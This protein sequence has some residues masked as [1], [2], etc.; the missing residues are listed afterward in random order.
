MGTVAHVLR[1][2]VRLRWLHL[3][4]KC[5]NTPAL[6]APL[7]T[8]VSYPFI[9][10]FMGGGGLVCVHRSVETHLHILIYAADIIVAHTYISG[11]AAEA[12]VYQPTCTGHLQHSPALCWPVVERPPGCQHS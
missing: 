4:T 2:R 5:P 1:E 8:S 3:S 6:S 12:K 7:H 11:C 10:S 9:N